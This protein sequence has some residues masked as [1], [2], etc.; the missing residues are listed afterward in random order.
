[1][2]EAISNGKIDLDDFCMLQKV[3]CWLISK[4]F[5]LRGVQE[6][7]DLS[8]KNFI[9]SHYDKRGSI[10]HDRP[11]LELKYD[12]DKKHQLD[13]NN[14][15]NRNDSVQNIHVCNSEDPL[16]LYLLMC[17]YRKMCPEQQDRFYCYALPNRNK[18]I[19]DLA[20]FLSEDKKQP[21]IS[22]LLRPVGKNKINNFCKELACD[23][24]VVEWKKC[25]NHCFRAYGITKLNSLGISLA[26]SMALAR[27][28]TVGSHRTYIRGSTNSEIQRL[29][30]VFE[31]QAND[32]ILT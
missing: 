31:D 27:H 7:C 30:R 12:F 15:T 26:E 21:F 28:E 16:D 5:L 17:K 18:Q 29:E 22:N 9:F 14:H 6:H 11:T 10:L 13:I 1:M 3:I 32:V 23:C 2:R 25:T 20:H 4:T 19:L 8:W 24:G